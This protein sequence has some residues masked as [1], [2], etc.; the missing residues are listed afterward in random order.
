M[1]FRGDMRRAGEVGGGALIGGYGGARGMEA[2]GD[3][4]GWVQQ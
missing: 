2:A 4:V 3:T 1:V